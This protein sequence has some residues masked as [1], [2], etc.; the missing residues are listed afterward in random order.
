MQ[1]KLSEIV[2]KWD[3]KTKPEY[4]EFVCGNCLKKVRKVWHIWLTE[5]GFKTE[6]HLCRKCGDK[7][8]LY[9]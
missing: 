6:V 1:K 9:N 5:N 3:I 7:F 8:S 4:R 2:S